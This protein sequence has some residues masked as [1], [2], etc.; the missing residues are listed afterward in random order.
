MY[1]V[2]K[3]TNLINNKCYIG[4][5]IRVQERWQQHKNVAFNS[6]HKHYHY[7]LYQAFRKYGLEN[8]S[9]EILNDNF[10]SA[11]EM[12]D[13]E[14]NMIIFFNSLSNGYNQTLETYCPLLDENIRQQIIESKS[15]ACAKVNDKEEI[16]EIYSSYHDAARQNNLIGRESAIRNVCKGLC[17]SCNG[18]IFRDIDKEKNIIS[19]PIKNYKGRKAVVAIDIAKPENTIIFESISKAAQEFNTERKSIIQCIQGSSRYSTVKGY[20]FRELDINGDII[21]NDIDIETKI[22]EYNEKHPLIN[23]ERHTITEWCKIYNISKNSYYKR[24]KKGMGIIEAI[25]SPKER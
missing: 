1:C 19:K 2:Y 13:Y 16:I 17:S 5:S 3:I 23:G 7:P 15:S 21:I 4:S 20:I 12:Q 24:R 6:N 22:N 9:F 11:I 8:F 14:K 25:I 18:L 10:N